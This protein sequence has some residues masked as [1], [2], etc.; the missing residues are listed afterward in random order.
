[1]KGTFRELSHYLGNSNTMLFREDRFEKKYCFPSDG[2]QEITK[3]NATSK[4]L[5]HI[6]EKQVYGLAPTEILYKITTNFIFG[7]DKEHKYDRSH[8]VQLD[9]NQ[10]VGGKL[11]EKLDEIFG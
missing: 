6:F 7:F 4:Y 1:M 5:K 2:V 8:F 10:Y 3:E 9:A 11:Q